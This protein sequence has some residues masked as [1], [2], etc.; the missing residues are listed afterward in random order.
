MGM[1]AWAMAA[2][3]DSSTEASSFSGS[4]LDPAIGKIVG[5]KRI[6]GEAADLALRIHHDRF[7][8]GGSLVDR[9]DGGHC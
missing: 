1:P 6:F 4:L 7:G 9:K 2:R 5:G 8:A 3:P